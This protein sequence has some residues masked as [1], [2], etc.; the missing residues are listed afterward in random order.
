VLFHETYDKDIGVFHSTVF[1][2]VVILKLVLAS[3]INH[4]I[5]KDLSINWEYIR[6]ILVIKS[7]NSIRYI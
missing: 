7:K 3:T 6:T 5:S 1:M 2:V 4:L